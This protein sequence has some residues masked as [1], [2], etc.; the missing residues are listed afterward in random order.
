MRT[1]SKEDIL[2]YVDIAGKIESG[3]LKP[4]LT[5]KL[6]ALMFFEPSTRTAFSFDTAMKRMNGKTITMSGT[7]NTSQKKGE[8]FADTIKTVSEYADILIIRSAIEGA[9]KFASEVVNLPVINAGDGSNQHPTQCLLDLY[10]IKKTQGTLDNVKIALVGDLKFGRTV[11]SLAYGLSHFSPKLYFV[12]PTHLKMS[13][14][15]KNDLLEKK[16]DFEEVETIDETLISELDIMYVTRI[17][18]ERFADPEEYE[19]VKGSYQITSK[20]L[21]N[22]KDNF[23]VMHPLPRVNEI[24]TDVDETPYA[25]YFEQARNGVYMREA[26]ISSLLGELKGV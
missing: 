15:I 6:A 3:E 9:S 11:H 17:Q 23:K 1:I 14:R 25:Y 5:D 2:F 24:T 4:D 13:S 8:S 16:V 10:S 19:K 7:S 20:I 26:L 18:K 12:S 21:K 22:V